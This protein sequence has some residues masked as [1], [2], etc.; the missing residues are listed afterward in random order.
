M[1]YKINPFTGQ[2]D[3]V[4]DGDANVIYPPNKTQH[5]LASNIITPAAVAMIAGQIRGYYI[6]IE[7]DLTIVDFRMR[8]ASGVAGASKFG[9]YSVNPI[10]AYPENLLFSNNST[11]FD[12]GITA[13]QLFIVNYSIKKGTYFMAYTSNSIAT[14]HGHGTSSLTNPALGT[15]DTLSSSFGNCALAVAFPYADLPAVFP[16]GAGNQGNVNMPAVIFLTA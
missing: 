5:F 2:L 10:T 1:G 7:K 13:Q 6:T 12:T 3:E 16:A 9:L 11:A 4:G 14:C 8:V 15:Q